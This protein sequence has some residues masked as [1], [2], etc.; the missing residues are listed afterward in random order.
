[1]GWI[2]ALKHTSIRALVEQGHLQMD[3]FDERNLLELTTP[4]YPG[5]RLMACR[6][7]PLARK[8]AY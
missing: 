7:E 8:R 1:M 3:L 4:D 5:E 2:T 6:N